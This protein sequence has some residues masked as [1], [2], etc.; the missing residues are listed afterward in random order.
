MRSSPVS[1]AS[2]EPERSA[3]FAPVWDRDARVLILG[4]LPGV[5]SLRRAQYYAHPRN[6]FWRLVGAVIGA[7]LVALPYEARLERLRRERI[8]LWDVIATASRRG[9]LDSAIRDPELADLPGLVARLPEL[10]SVAFNGGTS[11]RIGRARLQE[12]GRD[13]D[14]IDLP[15]SSPANA[16]LNFEEKLARWSVLRPYLD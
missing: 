1:S 16:R 3:A 8:A 11:A 15:S 14:L 5:E 9:S 6:A 7:D 4:T 13:L 10:R 12:V 2:P